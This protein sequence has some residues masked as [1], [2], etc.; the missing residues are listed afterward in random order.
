MTNI[1]YLLLSGTT[2][3]HRMMVANHVSEQ[4]RLNTNPA[5]SENVIQQ[6]S[7]ELNSEC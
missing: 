3:E 5:G 4:T 1:A 2:N 6:T 7:S